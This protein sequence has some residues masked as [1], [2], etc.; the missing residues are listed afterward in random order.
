MKKI[1]VV[2]SSV[3]LF[4]TACGYELNSATDYDIYEPEY[5][6]N[7]DLRMLTDWHE[8]FETSFYGF[9][10][11]DG[12]EDWIGFQA[13]KVYPHPTLSGVSLWFPFF[14]EGPNNFINQLT[15]PVNMFVNR[16]VTSL[17]ELRQL[18]GDA[19]DGAFYMENSEFGSWQA[20]I[21][22]N[23]DFHA[24]ISLT[25]E[26]GAD[27]Q[28]VMIWRNVNLEIER[29][30]ENDYSPEND[31]PLNSYHQEYLRVRVDDEIGI[32]WVS[33]VNNGFERIVLNPDFILEIYQNGQWIVLSELR[34]SIPTFH[35][36]LIAFPQDYSNVG[37]PIDDLSPLDIGLY[38][39]TMAVGT[40]GDDYSITD[41]RELTIE[42]QIAN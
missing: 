15:I 14:H 11:D 16:D 20:R 21:E 25:D 13:S 24:R 18:F 19:L 9:F 12:S 34:E 27:I 1:L 35:E 39:L 10:G 7:D 17:E 38:R 30:P 2:L 31:Y 37:L 29:Y 8:F 40:L 3:L 42:F 4:L 32:L 33:V 26:T 6:N 23:N 36:G 28:M 22:L 41:A 5:V